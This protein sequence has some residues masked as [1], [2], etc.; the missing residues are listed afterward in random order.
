MSRGTVL[1]R[2]DQV[3]E[4]V[5]CGKDPVYFMKKYAKIQHP[6]RGTIPFETYPFQ[7][8]CV[9]AF[10]EHR[11][12]IVLKSR[13]LGLSTVC[14]AYAA[15]LAIFYK[16]KNVLIIATKLP[17]AMNMIKKIKV[18]IQ[19]LP[20]WLLLPKFEPTKQSISFSNGSTIT[21]IP[22]SEDAGRSEALSLLIVD[23]AA[24]IRDFE[25]IWTGLA[26]TI[27][28]GGNAIILSTPM[29]V[30]GQYYKLWT[31]AEAGQNDFNPIKLLW[32][33]HPEHDQAWFD[34]ETK[35]LS[36]RKIAQESLCD[37]IPSGDTDLQPDDLSWVRS[38]IMQ[39]V[40]REGFDR[41]VW[42]WSPPVAGHT[43][44]LSADVSR[45]DARDYSTFHVIDTADCE[46]AAE[47]MGK[48]PP[49]KLAD[50]MNEWG[51]RYNDALLVP[52]NNQ[53]GYFVAKKLQQLG[54]KRLYYHD[55]SGD[56]FNYIPLDSDEQA[57]FPTNVKTRVQVL[58]KLEELIR[59][60]TLK[61]YSQR[62]YD[63][64]QAFVWNGNKPSAGKDSY[65][66]LVMSIAIG[67]WLVEGSEG[68]SEQAKAMA[69]AILKATRVNRKDLNQMPGGINDA[70]PL[71]NPNIR[72]M[73]AHSVYR[74]RDGSKVAPRNPYQRSVTD[75][76]WLNR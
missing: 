42:V 8:D 6:K 62:L 22:T 43:Y 37:F 29:G 15:W 38:Q 11:L 54:Y 50:L 9:N 57:G 1:S 64:L 68:V 46:V 25:D 65:D 28:T 2:A 16:D 76:S 74:P 59:H 7:D 75:F 49:E 34:K 41:N 44:I 31:E 63:Q 69:Y 60:K 32:D 3:Q 12:N 70:Q 40:S 66:D 67:C 35:S 14:A 72:G 52:E 20:E 26:P 71:V 45:G 53:Y 55:N 33:V 10:Q 27:S 13:Q 21:A 5:R 36:K 23:E 24:V 17:T 56:P 73:N 51:K 4:I 30:G 61:T 19:S 18:V 39:P 58:T 48:V 47:Y